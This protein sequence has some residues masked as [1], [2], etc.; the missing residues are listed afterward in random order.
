MIPKLLV[1]LICLCNIS[2]AQDTL[3]QPRPLASDTTGTHVFTLG[4]VVVTSGRPAA[5]GT[6]VD[7]Q[8]FQHFARNNVSAS[9]DLLP[10]VNLTA[11]GPRAESAVYVR[12]FD[13]RQTPLLL[14]G[15]PIYVPYDG[16]VDLARFTT[17]D[18]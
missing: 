17:F 1:A 9:L 11:V 12:G 5:I 8:K 10:G 4:Q 16:Y 14:D 7:A 15:I 18:L 6:V 13:L 3:R 2:Y